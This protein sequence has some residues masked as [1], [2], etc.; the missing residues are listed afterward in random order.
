LTWIRLGPAQLALDR[1]LLLDDRLWLLLA[2]VVAIGITALTAATVI[3]VRALLPLS[4]L[5]RLRLRLNIDFLGAQ[6][7]ASDQPD[8]EGD[9]TDSLCVRKQAQL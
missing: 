8:Q 4:R 3:A 6:A 9:D 2:V 5:P 1:L 7:D